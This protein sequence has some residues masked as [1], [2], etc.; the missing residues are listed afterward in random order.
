MIR[1]G[2]K[3]N[4]IIGEALLE[5]R[6][7]HG[8]ISL[9]LLF[10]FLQ[11]MSGG[12][13]NINTLYLLGALD[14]QEVWSGQWWRLLNANFL[15]FDWLHLF[16]NMLGLYFLGRFVELNLGIG[17]YLLAYFISGIG[18]MLAFS[19]IALKMGAEN[20]ILVG[21]SAAIMGLIGVISAIFMRQWLTKKSRLAAKRFQV[22]LFIVAMQFACDLAMPKLLGIM[23]QVSM[24][25]HSLGL[26]IGFLTGSF[27]L[28]KWQFSG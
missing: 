17:R 13:E 14:P 26:I 18:S 2:K 3:T 19:L 8:L 28:I 22:S 15:H 24:L 5:A 9:N 10:F 21:A 16:T 23:P 7:T 27:L 12:S 1:A 4:I 6:A 11:I 25:S 20:Q